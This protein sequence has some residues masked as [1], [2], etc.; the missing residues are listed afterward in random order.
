ME[1]I[2]ENKKVSFKRDPLVRDLKKIFRKNNYVSLF[3][4]I[5]LIFLI[6]LLINVFQINI[7]NNSWNNTIHLFP[8]WI[9]LLLV[10]MTAISGVLAY[11]EKYKLMWI[12]ILLWILFITIFIR[13][14]NID[15]LK[16]VTTGDWTLGPD[17]DPFLYLRHAKEI[18]AGNFQ[19]IDMFR[20]APLGVKNYALTNLMPWAIVFVYKIMLVFGDYSL[21]YAAIIAPVI[22]F[23]ISTLGFFLFVRE[24]SSIR[25][26]KNISGVVALI[27]SF[28]YIILP[29]MI[30]RTVAGVPEIESLGMAWFWFAFYFFTLAWKSNNKKKQI[31]Y[32]VLSGLFTGAMSWTWG[33]YRYIGLILALT[34]FLVFLFEKDKKKNLLI[35]TAWAIPTLVIE[36]IKFGDVTPIMGISGTGFVVIVFFL[37]VG[38]FI[39]SKIK[40][41]KMIK[42]DKIKLPENIVNSLFLLF[43]LL[44]IFVVFNPN[45]VV[46]SIKSLIDGLLYPFGKARVALTVAENKAPYF[47]EVLQSFGNIIWIFL[48][49][50]LIIFYEMVK[51]FK[52]KW[53]F[54]CG[55]A[56]LILGIVFSRY[57]ENSIF[58]GESFISKLFYLGS[59]ILFSI[60]VLGTFI[61]AYSKKDDKTLDNFRNLNVGYILMLSFSFFAMISMRG[62][63]RLFFIISPIIIFISIFACV[64]IIDSYFKS[65][66][67]DLKRVLTAILGLVVIVVLLTTVVNYTNQ[68]VYSAKASI[69]S[70]YNQQW[71]KAMAWVRE[72]TTQG[73]IFVHWWDYGYWIQTIGERATVTDG[74][75]QNGWWDH[76]TARYLLTTPKPETALSL[77]KTHNVSYLLID[78]TDLG[79]YSAYSTIGS[80]KTGEDRLSWIPIM[81]SD[82]K[83]AQ[84]TKN[85]TIMIFPRGA[86]LDE[87]IIYNYEG[88]DFFFPKGKA[89]IGGIILEI[90]NNK[91]SNSS[92]FVQPLEILVYN[93][94]QL[95]VPIRYLYFN[96]RLV[97]F[98]NGI[99]ATLRI[100]PTIENSPQ[101][102]SI[103]NLGAIIYLSPRVSQSL[104]AQMYLMDDPLHQYS[105]LKIAHFEQDPLIENVRS[106]GANIGDFVYY[107]GFR[108]PIKIWE[109]NYPENILAQ[110]GFL[111]SQGEYGELDNLKFT[112]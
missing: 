16:D 53:L 101:G 91:T 99:N 3:S 33:G 4:V 83:Y 15:G 40:L 75:H 105:S 87:D 41:R 38:D 1:D 24:I 97:D 45:F 79:K 11:F 57:S 26:S 51:H 9:F 72:N 80:D 100:I 36:F 111:K 13:T 98:K 104:F 27:A 34:S 108:G 109:V 35:L 63:V 88:K 78:S 54:N 30:H 5:S 77:M 58:N 12:P 73:S 61:R 42:L 112:K 82:P 89:G 103:N 48:L 6:I 67:N 71:Q 92:L 22:F 17:L 64:R 85:S 62:A 70:S 69:P 107:Q 37:I 43:S 44:I 95:R 90:L 102:M 10:V 110:A 93:N 2:E 46:E 32:G 81:T 8:S 96:D 68:T 39:L 49:G 56:L 14:S 7:G 59:L 18:V 86:A 20:Q 74:G 50:V 47:I 66:G 76:T 65:K 31:I 84:E 52:Q 23:L 29:E 55:F 106:Q 94:N 60:I 28:L 21:T 19:K 25:Y